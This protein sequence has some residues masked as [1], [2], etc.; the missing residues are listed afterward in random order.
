M[1]AHSSHHKRIRSLYLAFAALMVLLIATMGLS[2]VNLGSAHTSVGLSIAAAKTLVVAGVFMNLLTSSTTVRL[3]SAASLLWLSFFVLFV[4]GD[5]VT[6]GQSETQE[7]GLTNGDHVA[8]Y[9]RVEYHR[10]NQTSDP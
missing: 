3:V 1:N 8:S 9:D 4:M 7:H 6:R 5:Y 10:P 2:F